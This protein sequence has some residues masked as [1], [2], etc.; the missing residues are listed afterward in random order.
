M[1]RKDVIAAVEEKRFRIYAVSTIDEGI[2]ILTGKKAGSLQPDGKYPEGTI[3]YLADRKL[4]EL[5]EGIQKFGA[6]AEEKGRPEA[7]IK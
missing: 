7:G 2:E 5:A 1:L 4:M 6:A 3:N